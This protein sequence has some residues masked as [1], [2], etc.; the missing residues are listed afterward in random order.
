[1]VYSNKQL[2]CGDCMTGFTVTGEEQEVAAFR[3]LTSAPSRCPQCRASRAAI[4]AA[5]EA[6][7]ATPPRRRS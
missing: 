1:M 4:R 2:V 6:A 7:P 5:R 3:G